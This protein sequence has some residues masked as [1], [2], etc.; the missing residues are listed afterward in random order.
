M[1]E[2]DLECDQ[3]WEV[4]W[5]TCECVCETGRTADNHTEMEK[6][7][8]NWW[9]IDSDESKTVQLDWTWNTTKNWILILKI[10]MF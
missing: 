1:F 3:A 9:G 10:I 4:S 8:K 2:C 5:C 6:V 7:R